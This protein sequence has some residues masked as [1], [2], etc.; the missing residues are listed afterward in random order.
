MTDVTS[1]TPTYPLI[2][3]HQRAAFDRLCAITRAYIHTNFERLTIKPRGNVFIIGPSGT[4]KTHL[5]QQVPTGAGMDLAY[6]AVSVSEW[7]V[8]GSSQRGAPATWPTIWKFL[9]DATNREGCLIFLDELDKVGSLKTQGEWT[10]YQTTEVF[11]LLDRRIPRNLNDP[12]GDRISDSRIAEAEAVLRNKTLIV[13]GGAFQELWD[14]SAPIGFGPVPGATIPKF[15]LR[16]LSEQIPAEL[17]RRFGSQL[18]TLPPLQEADYLDMLEQILPTLPDHWCSSY[19]RLALLGIPEAARL[20]QGPRYFEELLLEVVIQ[21][22]L[23][24]TSPLP[25][26]MGA[27]AIEAEMDT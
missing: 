27:P 24:V 20:G 19:E 10:R 11:S 23:S 8:M 18:I 15:D 9:H 21:E 1:D 17:S 4:G 12:D 26:A 7:I 25:P 22:R 2:Y 5:A 14:A 13:A 16:R 6:L 3:P